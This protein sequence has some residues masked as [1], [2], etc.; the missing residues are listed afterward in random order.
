MNEHLAL[1]DRERA[2]YTPVTLDELLAWWS[3]NLYDWEW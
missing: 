3:E 2:G 1:Q